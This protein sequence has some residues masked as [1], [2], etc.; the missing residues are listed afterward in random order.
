MSTRKVR[1]KKLN[2][3]TLLPVLKEDQLKEGEYEQL[4]TDIQIATGVEQAEEKEYHL[5]TILKEAGTSNDQEIPVPPPQRSDANYNQLY[6]ST[7]STPYNYIRFSQ[8]VEECIGCL[9]DMT[10]EDN[11]FLRQY[12]AQRP[13]N[14]QLSEDEFERIMDAFESTAAEQAPFG[15]IDNHIVGYDQMIPSLNELGSP[16]IMP[17]AKAIY[18][19]WKARRIAVENHPIHPTLK[20]EIHQETDDADPYV[21]FRRREARQTRKTRARDA[22]IAEKLKRLRR[23]LEDGRQL[24]MLS[25]EREL[26]KNELLRF[27]KAIFEQRR[28]LKEMKIRLGIKGE[29]DDLINQKPQKRK[30]PE[31]PTIQRPPPPRAAISRPEPRP[32][33]NEPDLVV[34]ADLLAEKDRELQ[35]DIETKCQNHRKWNQNFVDLTRDPLLPSLDPSK[36][37]SYRPAH[38]QCLLTPPASNESDVMDV[39]EQ[40]QTETSSFESQTFGSSQIYNGLMSP[41]EQFKFGLPAA[42]LL[43]TQGMSSF[44]ERPDDVAHP[45]VFRRRIGRLNR[46]WI[47]RRGMNAAGSYGKGKKLEGQEACSFKN[48]DR[49]KY[50]SDS[51]EEDIS[52]GADPYDLDSIRFRMGMTIPNVAYLRK[53]IDAQGLANAQAA[54]LAAARA[55]HVQ[56]PTGSAA[57]AAVVAA[58]A[59]G[60]GQPT[61]A[62]IQQALALQQQHKALAQAQAANHA[63]NQAQAAQAQA[64]AAAQAEAQVQVAAQAHAAAVAQQTQHAQLKT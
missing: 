15:A 41:V 16:Y 56:P 30:L 28:R 64:A 12:N 57:A 35:T 6:P 20:F 49:W 25:G 10:V 37:R 27:D 26:L 29:D 47:D 24:V 11:D 8:T 54:V 33:N 5:Q 17:H 18:E 51:E 61:A 42:S 13:S 32:V 22:Q 53:S 4:V 23:E 34:L 62:Q 1:V 43:Q 50:D 55:G 52:Y 45:P 31:V 38:T 40:E 48:S 14:T 36:N 63:Q 59:A 3:K 21:C 58:A 9:Y 7:F 44:L 2:A 60:Q 39:D 46:L 19:H